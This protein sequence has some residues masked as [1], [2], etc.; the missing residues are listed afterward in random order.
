MIFMN[1]LYFALRSGKEH[2]DIRFHESQISLKERDGERSFLEYVEDG[3]KN[4]PGGLKGRHVG[5]KGVRHYQNNSD[6]SRCFIRLFTLYRRH[7]PPNPTRNS[8]YLKP[9]KK[10]TGTNWFTRE[11]LGHNTL[12]QAVASMCKAAEIPGFRTNHS[13]RATSATRLYAAGTDEQLIMERTGHRS[14]RG[15]R[16]YKRTS[17]LQQ[18]ALSDILSRTKVPTSPIPVSGPV[19]VTGT[20]SQP[21]SSTSSSNAVTQAAPT[22]VPTPDTQNTCNS[23]SATSMPGSFYFHSCNSVVININK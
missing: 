12:N 9:L 18:Q 4:R 2:R 21:P 23:F 19:V 13:L 17:A 3:S 16:S 15:V 10:T 8:F 1:G 5:Q 14:V 20:H 7:C 22:P 11:P 6:P